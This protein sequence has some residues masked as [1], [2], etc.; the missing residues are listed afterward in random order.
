MPTMIAE[1]NAKSEMSQGNI[2][3]TYTGERGMYNNI[4]MGL[5][6]S[7]QPRMMRPVRNNMGRGLMR[8]AGTLKN[9][10]STPIRFTANGC[11]RCL[12]ATPK[13]YDAARTHLVR[14]CPF[15]PNQGSTRQPRLVPQYQK[16]AQPSYRVVLF[17]DHHGEQQQKGSVSMGNIIAQNQEAQYYEAGQ[18][19][20]PQHFEEGWIEKIAQDLHDVVES[21]ENKHFLCYVPDFSIQTLK[22]H[23]NKAK[24]S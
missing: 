23:G 3:M 24:N 17:P 4:S 15:P 22:C 9:I 21:D 14:D 6:R 12:E 5:M 7:N 13:R 2:N 16:P 8:G 20:N 10:P 19:Y 1:L 18:L 11:Y